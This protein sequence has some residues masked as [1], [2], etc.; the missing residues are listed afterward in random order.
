MF[1]AST[2]GGKRN[3]LGS[4]TLTVGVGTLG[5]AT[6]YGLYGVG[7]ITPTLWADSGLTISQLYY[8]TG[9]SGTYTEF[10]VY[11][12]A[13]NE[14]WNDLNVGV[15]QFS[16]VSAAYTYSSVGGYTSWV[17]DPGTNAFG[18]VAGATRAI[19]WT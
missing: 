14:G 19:S 13:P 10:K 8:F 15:T 18:T 9:P 7:S 6:V 17:W 3:F 2:T 11:G 1:A 5:S 4:A 16:R 12:F